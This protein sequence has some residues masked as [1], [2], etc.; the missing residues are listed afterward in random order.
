MLQNYRKAARQRLHKTIFKWQ[1]A[2]YVDQHSVKY[3]F[4]WRAANAPT[5]TQ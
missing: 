5:L 4:E 3:T 1:F 2:A